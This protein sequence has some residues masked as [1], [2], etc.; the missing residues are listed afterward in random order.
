IGF[1][2]LQG[3]SAVGDTPVFIRSAAVGSATLSGSLVLSNILLK[4]VPIAVGDASG[5]Y[6]LPGGTHVAIESWGQGNMYT[7]KNSRGEFK[8]GPIVV[9]PK[10]SALLDSA[11]RI[12]SKK[13]P[14]YENYSVRQFV[15][16]KDHGARGDGLTDDTHP[17]VVRV[18]EKH[19]R[20][21]VEIADMIFTTVGPAS[22]AIV[23]ECN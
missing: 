6:V 5:I 21:V 1:D 17:V 7:G 2:L 18:G 15:S 4:N 9:A 23:V 19:S 10:P 11:G 16:A 3:V 20:G 8:R 13:H 12:F 14:Q 22:G